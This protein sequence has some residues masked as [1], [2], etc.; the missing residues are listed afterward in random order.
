MDT[1]HEEE[2]GKMK[3]AQGKRHCIGSHRFRRVLAL[4]LR[5]FNG[6]HITKESVCDEWEIS[7][8][9]FFRD[10]QVLRDV[11]N[12]DVDRG[13]GTY[14][15][16]NSGRSVMTMTMTEVQCIKCRMLTKCGE[17]SFLCEAKAKPMTGIDVT[18]MRSCKLH[19]PAPDDIPVSLLA[20]EPERNEHTEPIMER[21]KEKRRSVGVGKGIVI[22]QIISLHDE[23]LCLQEIA[24]RLGCTPENISARLK[25]AGLVPKKAVGGN[26][27]AKAGGNGKVKVTPKPIEYM[28]VAPSPAELAQGA[29]SS[30]VEQA[31]TELKKSK[32][33]RLIELLLSFTVAELLEAERSMGVKDLFEN[34]TALAQE[35]AN[36]KKVA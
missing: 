5:L 32:L 25:R 27:K 29:S 33:E 12:I 3:T 21:I 35:L 24:K 2:R 15:R 8:R 17:G 22:E 11:M 34:V 20:P 26:G 28:I 31:F 16:W 9:A 10:I 36:G 30:P 18:N 19:Q 13:N 6:S 7:E 23:G 1:V 14:R 4:G